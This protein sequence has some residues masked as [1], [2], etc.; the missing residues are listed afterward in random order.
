MTGLHRKEGISLRLP[1]LDERL[2][3]ALDL[4]PTC[5]LGADIGSDHGRLPLHLVSSGRCERMVVSD[6]SGPALSKAQILFDRHGFSERAVFYE[7]NGLDALT[8]ASVQAVSITGM[9]GDTISAILTAAPQRLQGASLIL[10]P[11][12][13]LAKLRETLPVIGYRMEKESIA[14]A[15]GRFYVVLLAVPGAATYTQ[16]ELH[17][18][19]C[20]LKEHPPLLLDYL[21]WRLKVT[22]KA[23]NALQ[24]AQ[25]NEARIEELTRLAAYIQEELI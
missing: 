7:A 15:G 23:L 12:T 5:R 3:A 21:H 1:R 14:R 13:E 9:G 25:G 11:H 20:L 4:Y 6:V 8:P 17:L 22:Q 2:Q 19:P 18:G 16:K 10:S 24:R